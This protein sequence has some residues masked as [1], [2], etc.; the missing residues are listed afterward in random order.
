MWVVVCS[1]A[2]VPRQGRAVPLAGPPPVFGVSFGRTTG[3]LPEGI[4]GRSIVVPVPASGTDTMAD[5]ARGAS[6]LPSALAAITTDTGD[7][8]PGHRDFSRYATPTWC[9]LAVQQDQATRRNPLS[10]QT[11]LDTLDLVVGRPRLEDTLFARVAR[12]ARA[13]TAQFPVAKTGPNE[14]SALYMVAVV[15]RDDALT[16]AVLRQL[17]TLAP[18]DAVRLDLLVWAIEQEITAQPT[19]VAAADSLMAQLDARGEAAA[20]ARLRGVACCSRRRG[21]G[22]IGRGCSRKRRRSSPW[23]TPSRRRSSRNPI[24]PCWPTWGPIARS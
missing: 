14:L 4:G 10:T 19:R 21:A 17:L 23:G 1:G 5:A 18:T 3:R 13:C 6:P 7:F 24:R 22:S 20:V 16:D 12:V 9:L 11:A 8:A 15:A 2:L